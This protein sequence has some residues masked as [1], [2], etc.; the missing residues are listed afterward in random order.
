[1]LEPA[2]MCLTRAS[3]GDHKE[4]SSQIHVLVL[5]P[6]LLF[7][8]VHYRL[9]DNLMSRFL[10]SNNDSQAKVDSRQEMETPVSIKV[11]NP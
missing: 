10:I 4:C 6:Q 5:M 11:K 8:I 9:R 2:K 7:L 1:M 3:L